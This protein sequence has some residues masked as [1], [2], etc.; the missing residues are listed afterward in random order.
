MKNWFKFL[1]LTV[2]PA[3]VMTGCGDMALGKRVQL[4][5]DPEQQ[6]ANIEVEMG[7]GL[8]VSL[9]GDFP[10][11][12]GVGALYFAQ[13]TREANAKIGVKVN[14]ARLVSDKID[15]ISTLPSGAPLPAAVRGPLFMMPIQQDQNF[16]LNAV[17]SLTPELQV[18]AVVG[19]KVFST[20]YVI[21]GVALCQNFRNSENRAFAAVCLYGPNQ[22]TNKYGG[23]FLG[24]TFGEV[25][26]RQLQADNESSDV[27]A[28]VSTK[29]LR[30]ARLM[31]VNFEPASK[32][33]E[34]PAIDIS[35]DDFAQDIHD[36][37]QKL[38][39]S[40]GIK[41]LRNVQKVLQVRR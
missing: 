34:M 5:L 7:D 18:G 19:M 24:G 3:V 22:T 39:G 4:K 37:A 32:V 1:A 14:V 9:A 25:L 11:A 15:V 27:E 8:E 10:I 35:S 29:S 21:P 36:P 28:L 2:V 6:T 20:R 41:T 33:Y 40:A 16:D 26:N 12:N 13:A 23:I 17:F 31:A 38:N 30:S